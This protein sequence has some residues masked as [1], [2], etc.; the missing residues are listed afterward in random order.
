MRAVQPHHGREL[1]CK[2]DAPVAFGCGFKITLTGEGD[3]I[4]EQAESRLIK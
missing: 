4:R 1:G 2:G 3:V